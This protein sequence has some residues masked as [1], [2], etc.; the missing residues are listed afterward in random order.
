MES[1]TLRKVYLLPS[2]GE[3]K[4]ASVL[5]SVSGRFCFP[6]IVSYAVTDAPRAP[7]SGRCTL[8]FAHKENMA[9]E[10]GVPSVCSDG[11]PRVPKLRGRYPG[12]LMSGVA[13]A[14]DVA[15]AQTHLPPLSCLLI[16]GE[17][18]FRERAVIL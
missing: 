4:E 15:H 16:E 17:V 8:Y 11:V 9:L 18:T 1:I 5:L 14:T 13:G 2:S 6:S 12:L 3:W 7:L 10:C